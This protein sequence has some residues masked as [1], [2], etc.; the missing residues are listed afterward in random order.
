MGV[1]TRT[2][3]VISLLA[4]SSCSEKFQRPSS[5][6]PRAIYN[7][8]VHQGYWLDCDRFD[9]VSNCTIFTKNGR[10]YASGTFRRIEGNADCLP[11]FIKTKTSFG[12]GYMLPIRVSYGS[13]GLLIIGIQGENIE[14]EI[15]CFYSSNGSDLDNVDVEIDDDCGNGRYIASFSEGRRF[16]GRIWSRILAQAMQVPD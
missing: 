4:V 14:H 1:S 5:V 12:G 3:I 15:E 11:E 6:S 9:Q 16:E 8:D 13:M 10:V 2:L 7:G